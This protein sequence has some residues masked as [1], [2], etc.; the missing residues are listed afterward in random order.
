MSNLA[1]TAVSQSPPVMP[2]AQ[3][4]PN[5]RPA[6]EAG[7]REVARPDAEALLA[8]ATDASG[9][10]LEGADWAD[11]AEVLAGVLQQ[12]NRSSAWVQP[13]PTPILGEEVVALS[14]DPLNGS[15]TRYSM[16]E[17][18]DRMMAFMNLGPLRR[19]GDETPRATRMP[20]GSLLNLDA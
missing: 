10:V 6:D 16:T 11:I 4:T 9:Q 5:A 12:I 18:M 15:P 7:L 19:V 17:G 2:V 13:A 1:I 14:S 3:R 20:P 8:A